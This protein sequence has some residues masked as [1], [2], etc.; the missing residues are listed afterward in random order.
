VHAPTL[1]DAEALVGLPYVPRVQDCMH[2][3]LRAQRELF[4]RA[5]AVPAGAHPA[6]P[7]RQGRLI[8]AGIGSLVRPLGNEEAPADGDLVLWLAEGELGTHYH[9]GTL[10]LHAGEQWVLHTSEELGAS[11]LQRLAE[12]RMWGLR[13]EGIYRWL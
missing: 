1:R 11:V 7:Q 4:G 9:A 13:L 6:H 2:L 3:V 5:V 12:C 8:V 10:M